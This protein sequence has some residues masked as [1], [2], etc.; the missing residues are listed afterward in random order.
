M[1]KITFILFALIAGTGFAQ[2]AATAEASA[3]VNAE[4]VSPIT[5]KSTSELNFGRIIGNNTG[6]DVEIKVDGT[7]SSTDNPDL[8]DPT[9]EGQVGTF[10]VTAASGY[11]Y[12]ISIPS[13]TLTGD[14][15]AMDIIFN[16]NLGE[17]SSGT[18]GVQ[19]LILGGI[20]SVN[21]SQAEGAYQGE[22][23]VTVSYN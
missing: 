10:E 16:N 15:E 5:V 19:N 22:V 9:D 18:G 11:S 20:L 14:G 23:T 4:I 21:G 3:N 1:K 17:S 6:G 2:N 13:T 7:R 8:L 12:S